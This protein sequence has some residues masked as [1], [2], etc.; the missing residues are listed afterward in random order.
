M[1]RRDWLDE[2]VERGNIHLVDRTPRPPVDTRAERTATATIIAVL[3]VAA[4]AL[5]VL[6]AKITKLWMTI[7]N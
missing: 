6:I 2:H 1:G 3:L 5:L 7:D 4:G